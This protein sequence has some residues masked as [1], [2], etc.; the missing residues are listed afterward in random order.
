MESFKLYRREIR[1]MWHESGGQGYPEQHHPIFNKDS[2][3]HESDEKLLR[4]L[5]EPIIKAK[6]QGWGELVFDERYVY[7]GDN[8]LLCKAKDYPAERSNNENA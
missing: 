3:Y 5:L 7:Y 1:P 4:D 8:Y 2:W 6:H